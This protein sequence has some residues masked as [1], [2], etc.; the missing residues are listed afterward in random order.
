MAGARIDTPALRSGHCHSRDEG[1][2][3][4]DAAMRERP[5][6]ESALPTAQYPPR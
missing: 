5:R 1:G 2:S 4:S 3:P 6:L